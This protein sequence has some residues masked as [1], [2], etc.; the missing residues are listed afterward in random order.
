MHLFPPP[1]GRDGVGLRGGK[2]AIVPLF[3]ANGGTIDVMLCIQGWPWCTSY[4]KSVKGN[5][6]RG[7]GVLPCRHHI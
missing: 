5:S 6:L 7:Y 1:L 3:I 2:I 4:I